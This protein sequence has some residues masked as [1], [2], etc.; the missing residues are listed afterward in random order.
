MSTFFIGDIHGHAEKLIALL[1]KLGFTLRNGVYRHPVH[2]VVFVGDLVDRGPGQLETIW[3]VRRMIEAGV[4]KAVMGNHELNAIAWYLPHPDETDTYVR[5]RT[6]RNRHQHAAFLAE[7]E[8]DQKL[9]KEVIDWFLTLPLWLETDEYRVVHACWHPGYINELKNR[10]VR[11]NKL[12]YALVVKA[13]RKGHYEF[14]A[15]EGILKGMEV[16]LPEG[17]FFY[18][19]ENIERTTTRI[20]WWDTSASTY[21]EAAVVASSE[22]ESMPDIPMPT[23]KLIGY[24]NTKPLFIGHYWRSGKPELLTSHIACVDYSAGKGGPLVAYRWDGETV[25]NPN[26]FVSTGD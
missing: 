26:N 9:H 24:D 13:A 7:T 4:A 19:K 1:K 14:T 18:D 23:E 20:S 5:R 25:L 2:T 21:R 22:R 10:L 11:G 6:E 15:V 12:D 17:V 8:H 3:I 16:D